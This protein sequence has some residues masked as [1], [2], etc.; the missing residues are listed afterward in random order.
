MTPQK[1]DLGLNL[2]DLTRPGFNTN[3]VENIDIKAGY[4]VHKL[5]TPVGRSKMTN[6]LHMSPILEES[7]SNHIGGP[8][9]STAIY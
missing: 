3:V 1:T 5:K 6:R 4:W 8:E 7:M 9:V 2:L